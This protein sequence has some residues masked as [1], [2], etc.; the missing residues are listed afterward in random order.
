MNKERKCITIKNLK[1]ILSSWLSAF[2]NEKRFISREDVFLFWVNSCC[3]SFAVMF[4]ANNVVKSD[5]RIPLAHSGY[6][7]QISES[8]Y[9]L[10]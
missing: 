7:S 5:L 6:K 10:R 4:S 2:Y 9:R 3:S 1:L 8:N